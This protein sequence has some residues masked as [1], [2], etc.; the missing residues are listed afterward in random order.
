MG[1]IKSTQCESAS[2]LNLSRSNKQSILARNFSEYWLGGLCF[3]LVIS[4]FEQVSSDVAV[5]NPISW[6]TKYIFF[7]LLLL[8]LRGITY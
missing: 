4:V 5:I 3:C 1:D 8:M 6:T 2:N 7:S